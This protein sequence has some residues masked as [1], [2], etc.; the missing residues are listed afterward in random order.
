MKFQM[1][2][3]QSFIL[4]YLWDLRFV[5]SAFHFF[6]NESLSTITTISLYIS[7]KPC[8]STLA[9][10][11]ISFLTKSFILFRP[12][13]WRRNTITCLKTILTILILLDSSSLSLPPSSSTTFLDKEETPNTIKHVYLISFHSEQLDTHLFSKPSFG[14]TTILPS[15]IRTT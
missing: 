9:S 10:C 1:A 3:K 2:L 5:N 7:Y 13:L 4:N 8:Q 15:S 6:F 11:N 12:H 14:N